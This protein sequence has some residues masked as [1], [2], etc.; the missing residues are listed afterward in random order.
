[1]AAQAALVAE[2]IVNMK[3]VLAGKDDCRKSSRL[4]KL[5][6]LK[7]TCVSTQLRTPTIHTITQP[8][9]EV[10]SSAKFT[11]FMT[12]IWIGPMVQN[13]TKGQVSAFWASS[14]KKKWMEH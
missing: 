13:L 7:L 3:R 10:S 8:A 9:V 1:M 12:E 11:T 2:T 6:A 14:L 5:R 4:L